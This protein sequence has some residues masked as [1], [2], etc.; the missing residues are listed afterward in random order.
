MAINVTT[1]Y[2][3]GVA[4]A[5]GNSGATGTAGTIGPVGLQGFTGASGL[6]GTTGPVGASGANGNG[7]TGPIGATGSQGAT[8]NAGAVGMTG[9]AGATGAN[10]PWRGAWVTSTSYSLNDTISYNGNGYI[11]ISAHTSGTWA[12]DLAYPRWQVFVQQGATGSQGAT[13]PSGGPT[14]ATGVAGAVG[15]T[16]VTGA[17]GVGSTGVTGATGP[18]GGPTGA[19][20]VQGPGGGILYTN[21]TGTSQAIGVNSGYISNNS[22]LVTLTLPATAAVGDVIAIQGGGAGGWRVSQNAGQSIKFNLETTTAGTG[23]YLTSVSPFGTNQYSAVELIC[24]VADTTFAVRNSNGN[25]T[26]V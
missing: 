7:G 1:R 26:F 18:S 6:Q 25:I 3:Q 10:Y 4:G 20:G 5:T 15:A 11:C 21:V 12:T 16:G 24:T 14:G 9:A 17:T 19:T 2:I 22:A 8:G 13:G 23:G